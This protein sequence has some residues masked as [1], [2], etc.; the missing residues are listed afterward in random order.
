M[1]FKRQKVDWLVVPILALG[2]F[3]YASY[4]PRFRLRPDMPAEFLDAPAAGPPQR[5]TTEEMIA[6]EYWKC[7]V[8]D[9]EPKYGYGYTLPSDPPADFTLAV[10]GAH[11]GP[12]DAATRIRYWRR[13][14][15]VWYLPNVWQKSYEW[16]FHWTSNLTESFTDWLHRQLQHLGGD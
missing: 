1:L 7:L 2:L 12:E 14:Q 10:S 8:R 3:T 5:P 15:H 11:L 6:R 13:A 16:D 4:Q 9:I